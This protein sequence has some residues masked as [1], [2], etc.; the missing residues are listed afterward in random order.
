MKNKRNLRLLYAIAFLQGMVFYAPIASL[1]RQAAGLTIAQISLIEGISYILT[2]AMELPW[3]MLADRIGY[4]K[5]MIVCCA[6]YSF[7]KLVFWQAEGFGAFLAERFLLSIALAGLS[8]VDESMLYLSCEST[9]SQSAFGRWEACGTAGMILA[10]AMYMLFIGSR[11]RL[12]ALLTVIAYAAAALLS[13]GLQ[14]VRAPEKRSRP[15]LRSFA[16]LLKQTLRS[17]ALLLFIAGFAVFQ[18]AVQMITVWLNQNQYLRCGM[19]PSIMGVV[20]ILVSLAMLLSACSTRMT[21]RLGARSFTLLMLP[22][23]ALCCMLLCVTRSAVLSVICIAAVAASRAMMVPLV[24]TVRSR[25]VSTADRATH[26]SIFSLLQ[27]LTAAGAQV[28]FGRAADASR[29]RRLSPAPQ[30]ACWPAP[31]CFPCW[32]GG[33]I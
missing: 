18:E 31:P 16:A 1:Y 14:E 4:R 25:C 10:S 27:N 24:N 5:T 11:Y 20:Y 8:G 7:S 22:A 30:P 19:E 28:I 23:A 29:M 26:L 12:A 2:L 9:E 33:Q 3:G 17:R 15:S 21:A 6:F 32:A 13:P